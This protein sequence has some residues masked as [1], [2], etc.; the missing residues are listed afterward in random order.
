MSTENIDPRIKKYKNIITI[1]PYDDV[2]YEFK[3]DKLKQSKT[4]TYN[5]KN[6]IIS[7]VTN[8]DM[9]IASLDVGEGI[10]EDELEETLHMQAYEELGLDEELEYTIKY[11]KQESEEY[12]TVYNLFITETDILEEKFFPLVEETK[13][14]DL[15]IPAPLL[16]KTLYAN[17]VLES[18]NAHCYIYF[19][20]ND[21]FVTIY[22]DGAFIYSK[23]VEFSLTQIYEKYCA[24]IGEKFLKKSFLKHL[25]QKV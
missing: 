16:Y 22:K 17:N 5:D 8:K 6:F 20:M 2:Y 21:A 12:S 24:L 15:L 25:N 13:Y 11:E 9:I 14:I 1:N 10:D 7:Y 4:L 23:S 19:T 3:N 18:Q